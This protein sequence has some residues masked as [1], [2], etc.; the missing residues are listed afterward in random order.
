MGSAPSTEG[1]SN[2]D[3]SGAEATDLSDS[4]RKDLEYTLEKYREKI[5]FRY[6]LYVRCIRKSLQ[7]MAIDVNELC[8]YLLSINAFQSSIN[9]HGKLLSG[10]ASELK[11][12]RTILE[13][14]D[15]VVENC[16]SYMNVGVF[17]CIVKTY[18]IDKGQ[19]ELKYPG[20][21]KAYIEKHTIAE[22]VK[23]NPKLEISGDDSKKLVL[24]LDIKQTCELSMIIDLQ[25]AIASIYEDIMPSAIRLCDITEG[26]VVVTFCV[27]ASVGDQVFTKEKM[28]SSEE[29]LRLQ[30]LSVLWIDYDDHRIATFIYNK[31]KSSFGKKIMESIG[32]KIIAD[33]MKK[34]SL[35]T[36]VVEHGDYRITE[37]K[38]GKGVEKIGEWY[39][40]SEHPG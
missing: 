29:K 28:L 35:G 31:E 40:V 33:F 3:G 2:E 20:H 32:H 38:K 15:I 27:S 36:L 17:Q 8:S 39:P 34:Y 30:S 1:R 6:G 5:V 37:F 22:F 10:V 12:A 18:G 16:S 25:K 9:L 21:L 23:I 11:K 26:C 7:E 19:E 4:T 24:K 13:V 14:L